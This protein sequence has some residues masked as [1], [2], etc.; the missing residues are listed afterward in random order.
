MANCTASYAIDHSDADP[1]P[2]G[3][4]QLCSNEATKVRFLPITTDCLVLVP[5]CE[6]HFQA[7]ELRGEAIR[8][9]LAV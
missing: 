1:W 5:L 3:N 6:A 2:S 4:W 7:W 8:N 9:L